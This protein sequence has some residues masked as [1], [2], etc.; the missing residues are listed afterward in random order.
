MKYHGGGR[1]IVKFHG[2]W[3]HPAEMVL[4]ETDYQK[5][6][7]FSTPMDWRLKS[8]MLNRALLFIGYSFRDSNVAYLFR[9]L[10]DQVPRTLAR[11]FIITPEPSDFEKALFKD[12][13][14]DVIPVNSVTQA[15]NIV[16]LLTQ[17]RGA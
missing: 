2:D 7:S 12:R 14:I 16:D 5:R 8:D 6:L 9:L 11:A 4:S 10:K 3:D 17:I 1:E 13:T 15:S